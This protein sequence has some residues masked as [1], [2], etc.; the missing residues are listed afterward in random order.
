MGVICK[1][2]KSRYNQNTYNIT[3]INNNISISNVNNNFDDN[4]KNYSTSCSCPSCGEP[5]GRNFKG[6]GEDYESFNCLKCGER[7]SAANYYRCNICNG[8]FCSKCP[9]NN[10]NNRINR[11]N[12]NILYSCP[13]WGEP[14]GSYFKGSGEDYESFNCLKCGERQ[15]AANYYRCNICNGIF[16][17][18]CPSK[19]NKQ[20]NSLYSCPACGEPAGRYFKGSGSDYESFNCLKCGE[21]QSAANYYICNK[22]KGIFCSQ[23]PN[24]NDGIKASCPSC[25]EQAG[26]MFKGSGNDYDS[27]QC[28]KCGE[29][30]SAA[31]YYRCNNC[32]G[33]FCY[34]C[35][36]K[37][38]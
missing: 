24:L 8:I 23:C 26:R 37:N 11:N 32:Q 3:H 7:Q 18:Q 31:N 1:D 17:S 27:F 22:C 38:N 21:R 28:L 2:E 15:S 13:A 5:A 19:N 20:S 10:S 30:Q 4:K 36:F 12:N 35:P 29:R 9:F 33:I 16:C 25:G 6:S 34:N 14:A